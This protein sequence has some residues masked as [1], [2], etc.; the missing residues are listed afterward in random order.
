MMKT[1]ATRA[2][3]SWFA[4]DEH[5][6]RHASLT[7]S[8]LARLLATSLLSTPSGSAARKCCSREDPLAKKHAEPRHMGK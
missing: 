8:M 1:M 3:C 2:S 4:S 7:H 6:S 5:D